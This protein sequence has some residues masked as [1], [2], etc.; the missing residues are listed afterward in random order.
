MISQNEILRI[1][2]LKRMQDLDAEMNC[3]LGM[4]NHYAFPLGPRRKQPIGGIDL[5]KKAAST[6]AKIG[7]LL[8]EC[9]NQNFKE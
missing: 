4:I 2:I 9:R 1:N 7:Y 3:I 5:L 8:S 6:K